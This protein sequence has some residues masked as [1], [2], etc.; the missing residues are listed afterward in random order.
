MY[1]CIHTDKVDIQN[2]MNI[3]FKIMGV[4]WSSKVGQVSESFVGKKKVK[5]IKNHNL[6]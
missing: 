1:I 4:K 3:F 6:F 5:E 2:C